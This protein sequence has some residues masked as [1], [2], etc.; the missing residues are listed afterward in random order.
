MPKFSVIIPVYNVEN[1]L[2]ECL[3]SVVKQTFEDIEIICVDDG[4]TDSS[5]RILDEYAAKDKRVTVIHQENQG[6]SCARNNG[7]AIAKGEYISFIDSDDYWREDVLH[8]L[9]GRL[10]EDDFDILFLGGI[11]FDN[12]S[13]ELQKVPAYQFD[14][15]SPEFDTKCFTYKDCKDFVIKLPVCPWS[16]CY[17][18]EFLQQNKLTFPPHLF[19]EDNLFFIQT[20]LKAKRCGICREILYFRRVHSESVTQN[21]HKHFDDYVTICQKVIDFVSETPI[22]EEIRAQYLDAYT[23]RPTIICRRF[24]I[25]DQEKYARHL[26]SFKEYNEMKKKTPTLSII[27]I[28]YNIKDEIERTCKS[29]VNQTW[30]DFEWIVVDG[31]STDGTVEVLKQYQDRMSVLISEPDNGLYNAMNKGIVHAKGEWLNFMNG[32][33]EYASCDA[34]EKVFKDKTYTANILQAEEER[35]DPN[36]IKSHIWQYKE[37]INKLTFLKYSMAHQSA[38]YRRILFEKYGLYDESYK[39]CADTE[40]N[41]RLTSAGEEVELLDCIVARFWLNGVTMNPKNKRARK[42]EHIR[43]NYVYYTPQEMADFEIDKQEAIHR[44]LEQERKQKLKKAQLKKQAEQKK[45]ESALRIPLKKS[46]KLFGIL[47]LLSIEEK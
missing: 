37:P 17:K 29:I 34:L 43:F 8:V 10:A 13:R 28:C 26:T 22:N 15:L 40:M 5:G 36:G 31:G 25:Q 7:M 18:R 41:L 38:F 33:D 27:T 30:Q 47:P 23:R 14:C 19:F 32:G 9:Y 3:D 20:F 16:A 42:A 2:K 11:N 21:W 1:Y 35:F 46:Y 44:K 12:E 4:S 6:I 24:D 45:D 39:F